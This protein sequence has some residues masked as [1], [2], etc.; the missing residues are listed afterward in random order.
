MNEIWKEIPGYEGS[1]QVSN[2]GRVK[3]LSKRLGRNSGFIMSKEIILKQKTD[4][5]GY[6]SVAFYGKH[7]RVHR[8]VLM[9]FVGQ[10]T[11][12]KNLGM[13]ADDN[14]ANNHIDNLSWGSATENTQQCVERGRRKVNTPWLNKF[15]KEHHN[16]KV[17]V[18][19]DSNGIAIKE[20]HGINDAHRITGINRSCISACCLGKRNHAGGYKWKYAS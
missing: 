17:I 1:Y 14:P 7:I 11:E 13:H 3:S 2:Y 19:L 6:K 20:F 5:D 9:A 4:K 15:G 12:E 18:Q 10:P 8:L 16:S